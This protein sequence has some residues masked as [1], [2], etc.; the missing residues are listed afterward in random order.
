LK[1]RAQSVRTPRRERLREARDVALYVMI[2]VLLFTGL[3]YFAV[4]QARTG[5]SPELPLKWLGGGL[6]TVLVFAYLLQTCRRLWRVPRFWL[7]VGL[8]FL[9]HS[10][11]TLLALLLVPV[12]PL[13]WFAVLAPADF[14]VLSMCLSY[15]FD[16]T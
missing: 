15:L 7:A 6:T 1:P 16:R 2:A 3:Y 5:G 10:G 11:V 9:V 4:H 8:L 12:V 14:A 13:L